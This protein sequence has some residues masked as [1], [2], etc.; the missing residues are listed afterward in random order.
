MNNGNGF[1][2]C[3][4]LYGCEERPLSRAELLPYL[5]RLTDLATEKEEEIR[6]L[7]AEVEQIFSE[8]ESIREEVAGLR[9]YL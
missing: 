3:G 9:T 5:D 6:G 2:D 7:S 8:L 4:E 1:Y